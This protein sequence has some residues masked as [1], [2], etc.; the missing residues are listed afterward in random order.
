MCSSGMYTVLY[1]LSIS[2]FQ[3]LVFCF[4]CFR[5]TV[6]LFLVCSVFFVA[7]AGVPKNIKQSVKC[8]DL[9]PLNPQVGL[10][11]ERAILYGDGV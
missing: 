7:F 11:V 4:G 9:P 5:P 2:P 1:I 6:V 8:L 10:G 3:G